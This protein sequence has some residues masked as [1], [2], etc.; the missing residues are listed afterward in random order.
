MLAISHFVRISRLVSLFIHPSFIVLFY[1]D[2]SRATYVPKTKVLIEAQNK[3]KVQ[4]EALEAKNTALE[5]IVNQIGHDQMD[6]RKHLGQPAPAS[7]I[8]L[9]TPTP[10]ASAATLPPEALTE[11]KEVKQLKR[12]LELQE[13]AMGALRT[14]VDKMPSMTTPTVTTPTVTT[15]TVKAD[16]ADEKKGQEVTIYSHKQPTPPHSHSL[17]RPNPSGT[18]GRYHWPHAAGKA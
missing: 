18:S 4:Y 9:P 11:L 12:R 3:Q 14:H 1:D 8:P 10:A 13:E 7:P 2:V 5:K 17:T 16:K 15:P 6:I